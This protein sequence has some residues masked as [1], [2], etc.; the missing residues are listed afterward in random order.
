[1]DVEAGVFAAVRGWDHERLA[2]YGEADVAEEAFIENLVRTR[3][4]R[5]RDE[6]SRTTRVR[7]LGVLG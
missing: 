5:R 7:A 6:A 1:M 3:D 4:R 2:V